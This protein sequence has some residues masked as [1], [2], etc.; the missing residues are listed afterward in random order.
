M[1][2][3]AGSKL[4]CYGPLVATELF[5]HEAPTEKFIQFIEDARN[6]HSAHGGF[7]GSRAL[8]VVGTNRSKETVPQEFYDY[9]VD[10]FESIGYGP[11]REYRFW[12]GVTVPGRFNEHE[13]RFAHG[14]P[15]AHGWSSTPLS[16]TR[17]Q[18]RTLRQYPRRCRRLRHADDR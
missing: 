4:S 15:H 13:K 11:I 12:Y 2:H 1:P 9:C 14:F 3:K 18:H 6:N 5:W 10:T 8:S 17:H 16:L 7:S